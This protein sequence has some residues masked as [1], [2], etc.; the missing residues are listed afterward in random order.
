MNTALALRAGGCMKIAL[1]NTDRTA[2]P[3][4]ALLKLSAWHKA[5][6]DDVSAYCALF[7]YDRVYSAKVFTWTPTDP[8]LPQHT[9][10]GGTGYG[11][12]D[13]LP[14]EI[15]H[16][17]PD[18]TGLNYSLGFLTRGCIRACAWC[19]VPEKEGPIRAHADIEEFCR[20]RDVV[21]MDNNVLAHPHGISQIEKMARLGLRVDFNQGL[22][23]RL[24][25]PAIA[26]R[27]AALR[28]LQPLRLACDHK[29]QMP[30]VELAVRLLRTAGAK[31]RRYSCYVLVRDVPDALERVEFLR[32]LNMTPFAQPYRDTAGTPITQEQ[33]HFSRWVNIKKLF[34][35]VAWEREARHR[36]A[37]HA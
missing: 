25:D 29:S 17:C 37:A 16:T 10:R 11:I 3:N 15:E 28:W 18:Y 19:I 33:R 31:P 24:I 23:G 7:T 32:T 1:H 4:L 26:R 9:I 20:H 14:E 5:R 13:T 27:L 21:L 34:R 36:G 8:Y 30:D 2:F 6:G 35:T 22:D 12:N